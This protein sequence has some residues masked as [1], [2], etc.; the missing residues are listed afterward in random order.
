MKSLQT[1][2]LP[3]LTVLS[4]MMVLSLTSCGD[5]A[6]TGGRNDAGQND[7]GQNNADQNSGGDLF[8]N[9]CAS[10]ALDEPIADCS[11][12]PLEST[13]DPRRDCVRR[14]NQFRW[15]C[16]CL[17]PL[18]QWYDAES[19]ADQ[20]AAY[21][22]QQDRPHAGFSDNICSPRGMA[23][24][25]CPSWGTWERVISGCFQQMWDEGPGEDYQAHGHYLAMSSTSYTKVACGEGEGWFVQNFQ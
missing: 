5:G 23:Q 16:Q 21:D 2:W 20:H 13:G 22:A 17:P 3:L 11:P 19:C 18:E 7:A 6:D 9:E 15:E 1:V 8:E 14:I 12:Q 10:G 24:N 4:L 25:E